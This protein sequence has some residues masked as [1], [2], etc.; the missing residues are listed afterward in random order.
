MPAG[1]RDIGSPS[2][3][4]I[5]FYVF[6]YACRSTRHSNAICVPNLFLCVPICLQ[7]HETQQ[8]Y[9]AVGNRSTVRPTPAPSRLALRLHLLPCL[10]YPVQKRPTTVSKETYYPAPTSPPMPLL[11]G[12]PLYWSSKVF[13][14]TTP[15]P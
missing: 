7:E 6:L 13:H 5:C 4:L 14:F 15:L 8:R 11:S 10:C 1:A 12:I 3:F 9:P 2:V